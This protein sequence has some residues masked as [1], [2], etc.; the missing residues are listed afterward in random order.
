MPSA[1]LQDAVASIIREIIFFEDKQREDDT[2]EML[3]IQMQ[4][5]MISS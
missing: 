1:S 2:E 3:E 4:I 5:F